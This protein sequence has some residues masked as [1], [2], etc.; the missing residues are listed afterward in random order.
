MYVPSA[1]S[2][3]FRT[4]AAVVAAVAAALLLTAPALAVINLPAPPPELSD[5][6]KNFRTQ[7]Q[8]EEQRPVADVA[9][10]HTE[11]TELVQPPVPGDD[12]SGVM[13][14]SREYV[15]GQVIGVPVYGESILRF[16]DL[17][18][19]P[20][21]ITSL[22]VEN[23]GFSAQTTASPSEIL[24]RQ[25]QGAS[26]CT[27]AVTL[28]T[29]PSTLIFT[30]KPVSL[31]SGGV[32]VTTMLNFIR[33]RSAFGTDGYI[34]P[35]IHKVPEPNPGASTTVFNK[36]TFASVE[37]NLTEVV[38]NL[39]GELPDVTEET[40]EVGGNEGGAAGSAVS[41]DK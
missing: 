33:M 12:S 11:E 29:Y 17:N 2:L 39:R 5:T 36:A 3:T 37:H 23:Q 20:W 41:T 19:V 7:E 38:L 30:L 14:L 18:G 13:R 22:R 6:L 35:E 27:L 32:D 16:F 25:T 24:I 21:E 28:N 15:P 40:E 8:L 34:F 1:F 26:S 4:G 31:S 9:P 10:K